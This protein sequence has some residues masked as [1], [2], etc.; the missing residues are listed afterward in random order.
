MP[1][2]VISFCT[3]RTTRKIP[4]TGRD[5][6]ASKFIKAIKE[7]PVSGWAHV[8]VGTDHVRLDATNAADAPDIF[9]RQAASGVKWDQ[10]G[11][12]ALVPVPDSG[13]AL[14][15][16]IAPRTLKLAA[17]LVARIVHGDA[18]AADLLRWN[19]PMPSA[20]VVGGT[21]DPQRL[22]PRLRLAGAIPSGRRV[23]LVDDVLT[24]GGHLRAAAAFLESH[25]GTIAWALCAGR[26]DGGLTV[27]DAF[28]RR[29]DTLESFTYAPRDCPAT[30]T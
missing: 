25:G 13:C 3:Y 5:Y 22:F 28:T 7:R 16:A 9:A 27:Q 4:W 8:P 26:A 29:I 14:N 19:E 21:R 2:H 18:V 12:V 6:A 20:H 11:A 17:A 15:A 1:L 30:A 10:A 24:T 23:V